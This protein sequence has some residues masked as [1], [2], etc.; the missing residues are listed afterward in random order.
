MKNAFE[1][2]QR[3]GG[4]KYPTAEERAIDPAAWSRHSG[5]GIGHSPDS[6]TT[7]R[8]Q[9]MHYLIGIEERHAEAP[10]HRRR[11][12]LPHADRPGKPQHDQRGG[13]R[14]LAI[15]ARSSGVTR[16]GTPNQASNPGRP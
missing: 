12:A 2:L 13:T 9:S 7:R 5:K 8:K 11:G 6:G 16:T 4:T 10:Q 3:R 14:L 1:P 15:I